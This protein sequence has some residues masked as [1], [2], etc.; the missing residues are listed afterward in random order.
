MS[1]TCPV[2]VKAVLDSEDGLECDGD[3]KRW[4]HRECIRMNKTE[5]NRLGNDGNIKWSCSRMD[6]VSFSSTPISQ[7]SVQMTSVISKLD[8]LLGK[9]NK[10][11]D[12]SKDV[13]E[14][15]AEVSAVSSSL[16]SLEP[17]V[18]SVENKV[19]S[20]SQ[21]LARASTTVDTHGERLAKLESHSSSDSCLAS[22]IEEINERNLRAKNV[23][24]FGLCESTKSTAEDRMMDD[25]EHLKVIFTA[26]EPSLNVNSFK[27]FR[28][29]KGSRGK[30]RPIKVIVG[31][32]CKIVVCAAYIPPQAQ[33]RLYS[34][35]AE[36]LVEVLSVYHNYDH[37]LIAGDFNQPGFNWI[38]PELST[39]TPPVNIILD[40]A[41]H[42]GVNQIS[43]VVN[44]RG[45]QLDLIFGSSDVFTVSH[46]N[47]PLLAQEPCHP[48][49]QLSEL[50][51]SHSPWKSVSPSVFPK[52]F[53]KE[54]RELVIL[55]KTLHKKYK[56]SLNLIDY[57][58]F[59]VIRDRC[60]AVSRD[61]RLSY[62][63]HVNTTIST[64]VKIFWSFVKNLNRTSSMPC[65]LKHGPTEV[66]HPHEMCELFA[67]YFSS[68]YSHASL[69]V[70]PVPSFDTPFTISD[71]AISLEDIN[72]K[73][74]H[75]DPTKGS[76]PDNITPGVLK[77]CHSELVHQLHF[78]FNLS[79]STG[80]FPSTLKY[81]YVVPIFKSGDRCD[82][83][84]YR[85]IVIQS[86]LSKIFEGLILDI[87][88]P[89]F[90]HIIID[91][92]HGFTSGRSTV[93][94]LLSLQCLVLEAFGRRNQV[95]AIYID[96]SKAFD[97]INHSHLLAKLQGYGFT[98]MILQWFKS[99]LTNRRLAVRL[100]SEVSSF[101]AAS[102]GVPQGSH[103][104]PFLFS[105]FINDIKKVIK[106]PF[107]L[108]AD[109]IKLLVEVASHHDCQSLQDALDD[110]FGWCLSN[111]MAVNPTKTKLIT[112]SRK[113]N[114]VLADYSLDGNR[115]E[116]CNTIKDLGVLIDSSFEF[117][118]HINQICTRASRMLGL[119]FRSA[120]H[121]LSNHACIIL[122]KS[123]ILQLLEYASL[124]WS[125]YHL[126]HITI[127]S[128]YKDA[129]SGSW[130]V[131]LDLTFVTSG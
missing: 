113:L 90:K 45:V 22:T 30:P 121:G 42:L 18:T 44:D 29:G 78:L 71:C 91:E 33:T 119:V 17:R 99:Y 112:F 93:T 58:N 32:S 95:D 61:C 97:K 103:L 2:C 77:F 47:D 88:Q 66:S 87:I 72:K 50:I 123:L 13:A 118:P 125:P 54:L 129:S 107:L 15:R 6:C 64:N 12:I 52:W 21:N 130:D 60:R 38:H 48:S 68:V 40:L 36:S 92:Q 65:S 120:R 57:H 4:F 14:I 104:G 110:V 8:E 96:F 70:L 105:I 67:E 74:L 85:P 27:F 11:D 23:M 49:F 128:R 86:V 59:S 26:I 75:L 98:G 1:V 51:K 116:R 131:V 101:F 3:C 10:I 94:N 124:V 19:D 76:G 31:A 79:L 53:S 108:F 84:N 117:G 114:T 115:V 73:L 39:A 81:G 100:G 63:N 9:V 24:V 16:S 122:Y 55:K 7:L 89:L 56:I 80:T 43:D 82:V 102:S 126:G 37:I 127:F 35:F 25:K 20:I 83:T 28:V 109:D 62:V 5:Y 46:A 111:D 41:A 34:L 106:V 69:D